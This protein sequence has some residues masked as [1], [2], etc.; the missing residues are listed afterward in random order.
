M[1]HSWVQ[2]FGDERAAFTA[3]ARA[4]PDRPTVLVDTY[5]TLEGVRIAAEIDPPVGAVRIDSG[6]LGELARQ[7]RQI[8]D[9]AGRP[10]IRII[11]SGDLE[12]RGIAGLV[13][14]DCP[15]DAFGVGTELITSRD[16]P[17][18]SMVYKLV[19]IDGEGRL[20]LSPGKSTYPFAKQVYR[21]SDAG[22]FFSG[23]IVVE[24]A[25]RAGGIPLL[26]PYLKEGELVADLP[27]LDA[28]RAT[29]SLQTDSLPPYVRGLDP[30]PVYPVR[31]S[32]ALHAK[33]ERMGRRDD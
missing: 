19:A 11:A 18:L 10:D 3:F 22:G 21:E 4:F 20:K 12:E 1:A 6:D 5:D 2:S 26:V 15:I 29:C 23:D 17:A 33:A 9:D 32:P 25:E 8:L 16:A 24:A 30:A 14:A 27:G 13:G 28:I 7:A 31:H